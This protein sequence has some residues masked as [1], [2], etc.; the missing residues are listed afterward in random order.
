MPD[1]PR[2]GADS[3]LLAFAVLFCRS[4]IAYEE[5][6]SPFFA[7]IT[8]W[9]V[10]RARSV[11]PNLFFAWWD[12]IGGLKK[13]LTLDDVETP[14]GKRIKK[15]VR[16]THLHGPFDV[17]EDSSEGIE[18]PRVFISLA[19]RPYRGFVPLETFHKPARAVSR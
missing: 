19:S 18:M 12:A 1:T 15:L 6:R 17:L 16:Q 13:K 5:H 11:I 10:S 2:D 4:I 8:V 3:I 7:A 9:R 14:L